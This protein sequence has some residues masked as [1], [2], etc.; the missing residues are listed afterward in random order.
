MTAKIALAHLEENYLYY[1]ELKR[2]EQK[3]ETIPNRSV[4]I[5][6]ETFKY[7]MMGLVAQMELYFNQS[8]YITSKDIQNQEKLI[9]K[10]YEENLK[11]DYQSDKVMQELQKM[12]IVSLWESVLRL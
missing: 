10:Y 7:M 6:K 8:P 12:N 9:R 1:D 2:M 4:Y 5:D 3:L 11:G